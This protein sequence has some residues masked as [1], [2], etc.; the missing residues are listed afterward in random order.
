MGQ[1]DDMKSISTIQ[2]QIEG[3]PLSGS[4]EVKRVYIFDRKKVL[5]AKLIAQNICVMDVK[6]NRLVGKSILF[7]VCPQLQFRLEL[8]CEPHNLYLIVC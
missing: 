2:I 6:T 4:D 8:K 5:S 3:C 7:L 1:K